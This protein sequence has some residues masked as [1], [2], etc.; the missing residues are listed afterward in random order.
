MLNK[1]PDQQFIFLKLDRVLFILLQTI[2]GFT[3]IDIITHTYIFKEDIWDTY[4]FVIIIWKIGMLLEYFIISSNLL[5]FYRYSTP[6]WRE[7][8]GQLS[9]LASLR[10]TSNM[11]MRGGGV[12]QKT[13][14]NN[15]LWR[16]TYDVTWIVL[17]TVTMH[18]NYAN[19]IT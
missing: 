10:P 2:F 17:C 9:F 7:F 18:R 3:N 6:K 8:G 15:R 14:E 11:Q 12:S 16:Q 19:C 13:Y 5:L 1:A 4:L